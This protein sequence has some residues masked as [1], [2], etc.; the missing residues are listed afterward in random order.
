MTIKN[1]PG[2]SWTKEV[3]PFRKLVSAGMAR[4]EFVLDNECPWK[5]VFMLY[6]EDR[7]F[8]LYAQTNQEREMW[9]QIFRHIVAQKESKANSRETTSPL[10][11]TIKRQ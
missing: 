2:K 6:S 10:G 7:P 5:F 3:I 1:G 9:V 8:R 11:E 4:A